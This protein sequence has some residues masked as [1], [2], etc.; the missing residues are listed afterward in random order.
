LATV[1]I[2]KKSAPVKS[3][4]VKPITVEPITA[5]QKD[6]VCTLTNNYIIRA[7]TFFHS[8]FKTPVVLFDLIGRAAGMLRVKSAGTEIRYNPYIFAKYFDDNL[9]TTIP[10]EVAHFIAYKLYSPHRV[11]PHGKEWRQVMEVFGVEAVRTCQYDLTGIP[12]RQQQRFSYQCSCTQYEFTSRRHNQA[13]KG[14]GYYLCRQC[15]DVIHPS[16]I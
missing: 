3:I 1:L 14:K 15:G 10:H 7:N 9:A 4:T 16:H 2:T 13:E 5:L 8:R 12:V 11:Q 6:R